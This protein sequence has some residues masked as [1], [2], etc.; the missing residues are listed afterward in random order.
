MSG[1][2]NTISEEILDTLLAEMQNAPVQESPETVITTDALDDNT[3]RFKSAGWFEEMTRKGICVIGCGGIGSHTILN[4]ARL[5]PRWMFIADDDFV[6]YENMSG[7]AF[8]SKN[9]GEQKVKALRN[10][11]R[12]YAVYYDLSTAARKTIPEDVSGYDFVICAVDNMHTRRNV[13]ENWCMLGKQNSVFIDGRLSAEELQIFRIKKNDTYHV[14][15]YQNQYLFD[16]SEAEPTNCSY[17]QTT[18]CASM[19]GSLITNIV[20]N[21]VSN[22]IEPN[23]RFM[24]FKTT[25]D[26]R[27]ML[28]KVED[29]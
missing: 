10:L 18:F 1:E 21:C 23:T 14:D 20:V 9:I 25:Y 5:N 2:N 29:L 6:S 19:I 4:L 17:K 8:M 27:T 16:D 11:A 15:L 12:D 26:C 3:V 13:F 22:D 7:Q 24:G 28:M